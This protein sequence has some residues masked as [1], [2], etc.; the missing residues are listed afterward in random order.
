MNLLL[1]ALVALFSYLTFSYAFSLYLIY[2]MEMPL[3]EDC[4]RHPGDWMIEGT[5]IEVSSECEDPCATVWEVK[6]QGIWSLIELNKQTRH[7]GYA[8]KIQQQAEF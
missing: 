5:E 6:I 8:G 4:N 1:L 3:K 7:Q 2:K